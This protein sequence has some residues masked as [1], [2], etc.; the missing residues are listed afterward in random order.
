V[1]AHLRRRVT[2]LAAVAAAASI[3]GENGTLR[4]VDDDSPEAQQVP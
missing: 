1:R 3:L 4:W 2:V